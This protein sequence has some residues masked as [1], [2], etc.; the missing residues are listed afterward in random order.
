[1]ATMPD[2]SVNPLIREDTSMKELNSN[3]K[4]TQTTETKKET[5]GLSR[6]SFLKGTA[7]AGAAATALPITGLKM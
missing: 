5:S 3:S 6:R 1:M 2:E 4:V 7:V